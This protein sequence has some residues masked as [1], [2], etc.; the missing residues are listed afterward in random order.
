MGDIGG[1]PFLAKWF[2]SLPGRILFHFRISN[3]HPLLLQW[4]CQEKI[5]FVLTVF[6]IRVIAV[7]NIINRQ[8]FAITIFLL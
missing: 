2:F 8:T 3:L 7:S 1:R 4:V 5:M 6:S